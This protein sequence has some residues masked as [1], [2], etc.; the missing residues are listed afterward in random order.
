ME[1]AAEESVSE[2]DP[3]NPLCPGVKRASGIVTPEYKSTYVFTN[4]FPAL[5]EDIPEPPKLDD[6]LFQAKS[7][8]GTCKVICFHPR[9]NVYLHSMTHEEVYNVIEEWIKQIDELGKRY[10]WVQIF[11]N[12][13]SM[14]GCSNSHPHCQ[15]WAS[16]F[17]PNEAK[18]KDDSQ[19]KYYAKHQKPLL[20]DYVKKELLKQE[21]IVYE[22]EE[23]VILVPYWAIWPFETMILPKKQITRFTETNLNQRQLLVDTLKILI[24][25]YDNLFKCTFPYSMGW[26]GAPTGEFLSEPQQHWTFHG[27]YYPPLLRS[28]SVKKFM[29]GYELFAQAQRDLTPEKAAFMLREQD[30]VHFKLSS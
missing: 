21:R 7:A 15:V 11:E 5:L 4:D 14:M 27:L 1:N 17:M 6:E 30:D 19:K 20:Q 13:G 25:K 8:R 29:V 28:A 18:L 26:H 24:S 12:R 2:Y 16:N 23:W 3:T 22:N 9:S 10:N